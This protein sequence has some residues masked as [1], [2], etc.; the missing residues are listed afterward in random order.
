MC[1]YMYVY[2][3][4][5]VKVRKQRQLLFL[6]YCPSRCV[7][8]GSLVGLELAEQARL[9]W[10]L[11]IGDLLVPASLVLGSQCIGYACLAAAALL[12]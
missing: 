11:S 5:H 10:S 2:L 7:E 4:A 9:G 3:H 8:I 12:L 1:R 6:R